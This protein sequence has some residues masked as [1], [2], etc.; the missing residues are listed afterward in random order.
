MYKTEIYAELP[1]SKMANAE[2]AT[3]RLEVQG[4]SFG[5]AWWNRLQWFSP[6]PLSSQECWRIYGDKMH[7][8]VHGSSVDTFE[9]GLL[10]M[11]NV[12][13][14]LSCLSVCSFKATSHH[15]R[16]LDP[17][18]NHY[19]YASPKWTRAE[20]F[21]SCGLICQK[22]S[23]PFFPSDRSFISSR[24]TFQLSLL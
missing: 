20:E 24:C 21:V 9:N 10:L 1:S 15:S 13:L 2:E 22:L 18:Q 4:P 7:F 3:G 8:S 11:L 19:K 17:F 23:N 6:V 12:D 5:I 14:R 16:T